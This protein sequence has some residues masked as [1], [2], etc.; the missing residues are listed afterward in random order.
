MLKETEASAVFDI[1]VHIQVGNREKLYFLKDRWINGA[2]IADLALLLFSL[3]STRNKNS[4]TV[5]SALQNNHWLL[6]I[7]G[8]MQGEIAM[9]SI[10]LWLKLR[11]VH[12]NILGEDMFTWPWSRSGQYSASSVCKLLT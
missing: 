4:R 8:E 10:R 6:D 7:Q 12:R 9:Q 3:V 11:N 1:L 5:A 2:R